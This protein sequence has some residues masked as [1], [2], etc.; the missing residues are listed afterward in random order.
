LSRNDSRQPRRGKWDTPP[1]SL[2]KNPTQSR[3]PRWG[4]FSTTVALAC[5]LLGLGAMAWLDARSLSSSLALARGVELSRAAARS[6][7]VPPGEQQAALDEL[8]EE[9][10]DD[11]LRYASLIAR[12]GRVRLQAGASSLKAQQLKVA[13]RSLRP[14]EVRELTASGTALFSIGLG[15]PPHRRSHRHGPR[16]RLVVEYIPVLAQQARARAVTQ[17]AISA[18]AAAALLAAAVLFWRLLARAQR[19][20]AQMARD[21]RLAALGEMSAV[22][23]HELRN[24]LASLKGHAQLLEELLV[25]DSP[26]REKAELIVREAQRLERLTSQV[27][28]FAR[29]GELQRRDEDPRALAEAA[30]SAA[31]DVPTQL[32]AEASPDRWSLDRPR[33]EQALGNLVGNAAE[34]TVGDDPVELE[35]SRDGANLCFVVRDRGPGIVQSELE[36]V[37]EPFHTGKLRGTGLGLA[38][39]RRIAE[40]HGGRLSAANRSDGGAE[41]TLTVPEA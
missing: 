21:R 15:G 7:R 19:A 16:G 14:Q 31:G 27:L 23:G 8:I 4:L 30:L 40:A 34:A 32:H 6:L 22:L 24:P 11:G 38:I 12:R 10:A 36:Q 35:I 26:V 29:S 1:F 13:L 37:F 20:E 28:D 17:L 33:L 25:A 39:A 9:L 2:M 3:W 18:V 5:A 41:L